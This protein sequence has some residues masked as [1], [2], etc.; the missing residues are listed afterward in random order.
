MNCKMIAQADSITVTGVRRTAALT[1]AACCLSASCR[2]AL[3]PGWC[4]CHLHGPDPAVTGKGN[5]KGGRTARPARAAS[6]GGG[7]G[8]N[9]KRER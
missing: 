1:G 6:H 5:G 3:P 2:P 7:A 4:L 8:A 9:R